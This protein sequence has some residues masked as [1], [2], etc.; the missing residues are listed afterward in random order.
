MKLS[1]LKLI[2]LSIFFLSLVT[3]TNA[4]AQQSVQQHIL[5]VKSSPN[6][7]YI[8]GTGVYDE[9]TLVKIEKV[10]DEWQEYTFAGW[11]IDGVWTSANPVSI[12]M[13][14]A[15]TVEA[16]YTKSIGT[17]AI[18]IDAIP[19][20]TSITV[21]GT[22]Y[23]A[24]ELPLSF[25]WAVGSAHTISILDVVKDTPNTR[26]KFDSWKDQNEQIDRTITVDESSHNFIAI[27][28]TQHFLKP[29][30]EYGSVMGGGWQD[31]GSS[32]SFELE[33]DVVTDKKNENIR[34][35]FN[36]WDVGDYLNSPTNIVDVSQP[37]SVKA[38]WDKQ[39][40]LELVTNIPDYKPFGSGWYE[41]GRQV[42]LIAEETLTSPNSDEEYAFEKWV[43]KGP[44]PIII[45][46]AHEPSTTITMDQPYIIEA[47]YKKAFRVNV[48]TPY[49]SAVGS[50]FYPEGST[51]EITMSQP[52]VIVDYKKTKKVFSGWDTHGAKTMNFGSES[53]YIEE[54]MAASYQNL[55]VIVDRPI[56]ITANWKTQHYL[57]VQSTEGTVEGS[58]WYDIGRL[59]PVSAKLP[60]TPPGMWSKTVFDKWEGDYDG[61]TSNGRVMMNEPKTIIA[62]YRDDSTPALINSIILGSVGGTALLIY[63]KTRNGKLPL[64]KSKKQIPFGEQENGFDKFFNTRTRSFDYLQKPAFLSSKPKIIKKIID[65]LLDK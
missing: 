37:I 42:A 21:D 30:S 33:S 52:E 55:V 51:A 61:V 54:G 2:V 47:K 31:Q 10:P 25:D 64:L 35:V 40:K 19:R 48:W 63:N 16:I 36:S 62:E 3:I 5:E 20:I 1:P 59:V 22:I 39:N 14:K 65:W 50:G 29:I 7:L 13:D 32:V 53:E 18:L 41:E 58:G 43:S 44:N 11:K 15:H 6:I 26:H 46:N 56:N 8:P 38:N 28:K 49:G 4:S 12:L 27:Y 60:T 45:P 23:L 9:G 57:D 17:G 24:D 34:Y